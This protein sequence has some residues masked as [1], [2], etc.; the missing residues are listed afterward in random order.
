MWYE[1][2]GQGEGKKDEVELFRRWTE[3]IHMRNEMAG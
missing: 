2:S 1:K 3:I